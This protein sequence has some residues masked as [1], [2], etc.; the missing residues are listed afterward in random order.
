MARATASRNSP[1]KKTPA[2][3]IATA[4]PVKRLGADKSEKP[5][6][7]ARKSA[8]NTTKSKDATDTNGED[9]KALVIA[10]AAKKAD[11]KAATENHDSGDE[12]PT[13]ESSAEDPKP[14]PSSAQEGLPPNGQAD[15][16]GAAEVHNSINI[17]V[18]Y[19]CI[20]FY[21]LHNFFALPG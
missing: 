2:K 12:H 11:E 1:G 4:K 20:I 19:L 6:V 3:K 7:E 18:V 9:P 13:N 8:R 16:S 21:S 17:V 10:E 14:G 5:L 15:E